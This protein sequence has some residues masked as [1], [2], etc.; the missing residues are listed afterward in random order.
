MKVA[1]GEQI[2]DETIELETIGYCHY[3]RRIKPGS[4]FQSE[5]RNIINH[6]N[7]IIRKYE[8]ADKT[9]MDR[10]I[11]LAR[12]EGIFIPVDFDKELPKFA[13]SNL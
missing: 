13:I 12:A 7:E 11:G 8:N 6:R 2:P 3:R 5:L 1:Y 10:L 4:Y 9:C